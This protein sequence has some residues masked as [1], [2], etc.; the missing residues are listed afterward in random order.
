MLRHVVAMASKKACDKPAHCRRLRWGRF[1]IE[2]RVRQKG[3]YR[4][5]VVALEQNLEFN[6]VVFLSERALPAFRFDVLNHRKSACCSIP[7]LHP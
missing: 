5:I 1:L 3:I 7:S 2:L 6:E 4:D